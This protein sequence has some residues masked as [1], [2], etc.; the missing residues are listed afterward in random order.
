M[1]QFLGFAVGFMF[2]MVSVAATIY[3]VTML[4]H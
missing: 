2:G 4:C 3:T 1:N